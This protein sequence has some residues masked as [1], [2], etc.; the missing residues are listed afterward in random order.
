[1]ISTHLSD[2]LEQC[3][4]ML[5]GLTTKA[6]DIQGQLSLYKD[7]GLPER[8]HVWKAAAIT[9]LR[10]TMESKR[11]LTRHIKSLKQR[12]AD[13][14][15]GET[16]KTAVKLAVAKVQRELM[17]ERLKMSELKTFCRERMPAR[18]IEDMYAVLDNA[19]AKF[20]EYLPE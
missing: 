5:S 17:R 18:A 6:V 9:S 10:Y 16:T 19:E 8:D 2:N 11:N 13:A 7:G 4:E 3:E 20:E 15:R 12:D 1:M 14:R